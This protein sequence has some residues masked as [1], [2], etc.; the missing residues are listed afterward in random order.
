[1]RGLLFSDIVISTLRAHRALVEDNYI[2]LTDLTR[3]YWAPRVFYPRKPEL[4]TMS[5][6]QRT[7]DVKLNLR[8][9]KA[10]HRRLQQAAKANNS[11]LQREIV[12]RLDES[13]SSEASLPEAI[14]EVVRTSVGSALRE[15]P[16]FNKLLAEERA[17]SAAAEDRPKPESK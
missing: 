5:P 17:K 7:T 2:G 8:L 15:I 6:E 12:R 10:Q 13:F 11:T 3:A 1:L 16:E 14:K 4:E 9:T